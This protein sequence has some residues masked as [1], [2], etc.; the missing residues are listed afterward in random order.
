MFG[1]TAIEQYVATGYDKVM[2][3]D[4]SLKLFAMLDVMPFKEVTSFI[5]IVLVVVFFVT[6][7]DSGALVVDTIA[8]GGK[9][10]S[11]LLQ[12]IFW[13]LFEGIVAISLMLGGGLIA[14]QAMVVS[15]GLPFAVVLL[16]AVFSLI[17]GLWRELKVIQKHY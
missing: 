4:L 11:P 1:G 5:G 7:S 8:A 13:C 6:S 16:V 15:T 9:A 14:T 2:E 12:R 3:V 10:H 17:K